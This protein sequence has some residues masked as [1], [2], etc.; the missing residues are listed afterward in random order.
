M[1]RSI[2]RVLEMVCHRLEA[3]EAGIKRCILVMSEAFGRQYDEG[4][5]ESRNIKRGFTTRLRSMSR[6]LCAIRSLGAWLRMP[7]IHAHGRL[8]ANL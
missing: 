1:G 4:G 2:G 7:F 6:C 8:C 3:E 5:R